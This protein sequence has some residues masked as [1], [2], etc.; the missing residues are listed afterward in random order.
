MR[1]VR[2]AAGVDTARLD[3]AIYSLMSLIGRYR[4]VP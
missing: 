4:F 1:I 3:M 2:V